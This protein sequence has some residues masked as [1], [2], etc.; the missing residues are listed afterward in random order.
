MNQ[1]WLFFK[2]RSKC[3]ATIAI[4]FNLYQI[5]DHR[6]VNRLCSKYVFYSKKLYSTRASLSGYFVQRQ[7]LVLWWQR[8]KRQMMVSWQHSEYSDSALKS[9]ALLK[10]QKKSKSCKP[11]PSF[12]YLYVKKTIKIFSFDFCLFFSW[13]N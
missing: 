1:K 4:I 13:F 3:T 12:V 6:S 8:T 7:M 9:S 11:Y 10:T 5:L 2:I